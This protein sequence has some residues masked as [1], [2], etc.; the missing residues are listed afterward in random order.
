[1]RS[2]LTSSSRCTGAERA[3]RGR[4]KSWALLVLAPFAVACSDRTYAGRAERHVGMVTQ[5]AVETLRS[6]EDGK[7]VQAALDRYA[8]AIR[9]AEAFLAGQSSYAQRS[10]YRKFQALLARHREFHGLVEQQESAPHAA[11]ATGENGDERG[12]ARAKSEWIQT[13]NELL[14]ESGELR[15][16]LRRGE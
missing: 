13:M 1:M 6:A 2:T 8:Q 7:G 11:A 14:R 5:A 10:S 4:W 16:L 12:H 3:G 9:E 15:G